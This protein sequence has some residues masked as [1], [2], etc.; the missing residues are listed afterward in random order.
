[1]RR[2]VITGLGAITPL[3]LTKNKNGEN[4][5]WENILDGNSSVKDI[6]GLEG[7]GVFDRKK[8]AEIENFDITDY[9]EVRDEAD[10]KKLNKIKNLDKAVQFATIATKLALEDSKINWEEGSDFGFYIGNGMQ[11][12][13]TIEKI[14]SRIVHQYACSFGRDLINSLSGI[15][16]DSNEDILEKLN[17]RVG[18]LAEEDVYSYDESIFSI[19]KEMPPTIFNSLNY[20]ISGQV[21]RYFNLHGPTL[22]FSTA[23]SSGS[24]AI[25][26]A[27]RSIKEGDADLI[28]AGGTEAP[29]SHPVVSMF[30]AL[31]VM[32][33]NGVKPCDMD[34]DGFA[35]GEGSGV[36]VMEELEHAKKRG[37]KIY[38]EFGG[39]GQTNDGYSMVSLLKSGEYVAK[40]IKKAMEN[41]EISKEY[42]DYI[43]PH[44]TST[45]QCD[46]VETNALRRVFGDSLDGKIIHPT[47]HLTG[48]F[49]AGAGGV[50]AVLI[51]EIMKRKEVPGFPKPENQDPNCFR[52][53]SERRQF[54][55][56]AA[57]SNSIGF[58]GHNCA[59][60]F[61]KYN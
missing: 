26:Q 20:A 50:E 7:I 25:G 4:E 17:E 51:N 41:A 27:Y 19:F 57:L 12:I 35:L 55:V 53:N 23:C 60:I 47:K 18:R 6:N 58:G 48:H 28:V 5:F 34:R 2:V 38:S 14:T 49:Q 30:N 22:A 9:L 59:I 33:K 52:Y 24:D 46:I 43:N 37:A 21:S 40:A 10:K 15:N 42:I 54:E 56:N 3:G 45:Q 1:M 32:S 31:G 39:Y 29:I 16:G 44:S 8:G 61:K 36:L 11:G 13:Q